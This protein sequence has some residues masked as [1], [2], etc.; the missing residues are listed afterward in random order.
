M[1]LTGHKS[2]S[3]LAIYQKVKDDDK[4]RMGYALGFHLLQAL[5][6]SVLSSNDSSE[7]VNAPVPAIDAPS[8]I[9]PQVIQNKENISQKNAILPFEANWN[10]M[11]DDGIDY[12]ALLEDTET[13]QLLLSQIETNTEASSTKTVSKQMVKKSSPR[14]PL[15][16]SN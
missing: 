12:L 6:P 16:F 13:D 5:P 2:T 10:E 14:I 8:T 9:Q 11:P 7:N 15:V 1:S 4:I 3:S